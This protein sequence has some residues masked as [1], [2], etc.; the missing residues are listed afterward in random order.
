MFDMKDRVKKD[1][2]KCHLIVDYVKNELTTDIK[3]MKFFCDSCLGQNKI[4]C[5]TRL[6]IC[7]VEFKRF[8]QIE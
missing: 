5:L 4:N 7:F 3:I 2:M 8:Y 6:L 1:P